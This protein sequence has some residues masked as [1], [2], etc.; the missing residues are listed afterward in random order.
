M[1]ETS[2]LPCERRARPERGSP[3]LAALERGAWHGA[4][5]VAI[6]ACPAAFAYV[7]RYYGAIDLPWTV[8]GAQFAT[9]VPIC[10]AFYGAGI[11]LGAALAREARDP[12]ARAL[13]AVGLPSSFG[14]I[15]GVPPGAFAAEHFGSIDAPYFGTAEIF[16]AGV[17]AFFLLGTALLRRDGARL[18]PAMLSLA[19]ALLLPFVCGV[20]IWLAAPDTTWIADMIVLESA[21][22]APSLAVF[23]AIFGA[24]VGALFGG[25]LGLAR[26]LLMGAAR[27]GR[28]RGSA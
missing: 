6:G 22:V 7:F 19:I 28:P 9:F 26:V 3:A 15:F 10:G 13:L 23:G 11:A 8:L 2:E 25:L 16:V 1:A 14:A 20:A 4:W 12:A 18:I 27:A 24:V 17:L 21:N 5:T